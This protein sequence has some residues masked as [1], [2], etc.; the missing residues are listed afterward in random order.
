[1]KL[2]TISQQKA[3]RAGHAEAVF[4]ARYLEFQYRFVDFFVEHL[5]DLSLV[6]KGDLQMM[7]TL[8]VVGQ[9]KIRTVHDAIL[10]GVSPSEADLLKNGITASRIAEIISVPRQTV[11]RKLAQL[12]DQ[13]WVEQ[14]P[15]QSWCISSIGGQDSV[16]AALADIDR[17]AITRVASFFTSLEGLLAAP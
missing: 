11:R 3:G 17:R 10:S 2:P 15:D 1:M 7:L 13:G 4:S 16:R 9:V 12:R 6:F 14:N 8:A 5:G